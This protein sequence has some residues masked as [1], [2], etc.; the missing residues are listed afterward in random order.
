MNIVWENFIYSTIV[1]NVLEIF[2]NE[3]HGIKEFGDQ[4]DL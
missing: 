2:Y 1:D 3:G 4:N